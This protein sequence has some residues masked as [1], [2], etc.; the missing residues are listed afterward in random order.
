MIYPQR[1]HDKLENNHFEK[2]NQLFLWGI[3][4]SYV[5]KIPV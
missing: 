5:K 3:F 1:L 2:E 4:N